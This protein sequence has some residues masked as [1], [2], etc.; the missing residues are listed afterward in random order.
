MKKIIEN[1]IESNGFPI[2][3]LILIYSPRLARLLLGVWEKAM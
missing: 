3:I 1:T 2:F